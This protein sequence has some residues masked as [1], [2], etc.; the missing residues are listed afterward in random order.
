MAILSVQSHVAYGHVGNSAAVFPLQRLGHDVWPVNTVHF[1]NH[2]GHGSF[3]GEIESPDRV[4]AILDGLERRGCWETCEAVMSGYLGHAG[5]GQALLDTVTSIKAVNSNAIYLCDPVIGDAGEGVYVAP[6]V[7]DFI[8]DHLVPQADFLI[9]NVFEL[10][11]LTGSA[12]N[13]IDEVIVAARRLLM[14]GPRGAIVSSVSEAS[15][16]GGIKT[17]LVTA[18][19]AVGV[20]T[21]KIPFAAKGSGDLLS[22]LWLGRYLKSGSEREALE[23]ALSSLFGLIEKTGKA[24]GAELPLIREQ[25]LITEPQHTFSAEM[26]D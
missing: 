1:S 15:G 17:V 14:R 22:A 8:R 16:V 20:E 26:Y 11:I 18:T 4:R 3:G 19:S 13:G 9:P 21:P 2:P 25:D 12:V 23:L 5:T 24:D 10:G 6:G 7:V